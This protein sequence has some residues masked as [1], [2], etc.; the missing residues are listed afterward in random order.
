MVF[1]FKFQ[2]FKSL[3]QAGKPDGFSW[4]TCGSNVPP[5]TTMFQGKPDGFCGG[6]AGATSLRHSIQTSIPLNQ[7]YP[8]RLAYIKK[9]QYLCGVFI[10]T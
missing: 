10:K 6:R 4:G 9:K 2:R 1:G 3:Y 7:N 8:A 5:N